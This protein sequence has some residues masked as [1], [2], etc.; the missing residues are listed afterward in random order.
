M[1]LRDYWPTAAP[2]TTK[3][4]TGRAA[5]AHAKA[6]ASLCDTLFKLVLMALAFAAAALLLR[7]TNAIALHIPHDPNEGWNAYLARAAMTGGPLYPQGLMVNNYP[8]LSFY[9]VAA[10][11]TITGDPIVAGRLL[12]LAAF[13]A[14]AISIIA[15]LREMGACVLGALFG[16]LFF[17]TGLLA[18]SGYVAMNDPQMLGHALQ[19]GALSLLLQKNRRET[20]PAALAMAAGLFI[21]HNLIALPLAAAMW[22]AWQ[23]RRAAVR[24][25][26]S[27]LVFCVAGLVLVRLLLDVNLFTALASPRLWAMKNFLAGSGQFLSWSGAGLVATALQVWRGRADAAVRLVA[28][29]SGFA[30]AIG[31]LF[32]FGDGVDANIFFDAAIALSLGAG[33]ALGNIPKRWASTLALF[34]ALPL[35]LYLEKNV[36]ASNFSFSDVFAREARLDIGFVRAHPGPA[37]CEDLTLCFWAGKEEPVDVFNLSEAIIRE[38]RG[39]GDLAHLL[40]TQYFGSIA[41][42]SLTP[43]ALGP[44]L[45][46]VLLAHY[47]TV[48]QD[49]NGV[50]MERR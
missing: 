5:D 24:F 36:T 47:R 1:S 42:S 16:A 21:K 50:F 32:A 18:A 44:H 45:N 3:F 17:A 4:F 41:L 7:D 25:S 29:Y 27:G 9:V 28:L 43:F 23:D 39:D 22:L 26:V 46:S 34:V 37:L 6:Q 33:L 13:I 38:K 48:R 31:G 49:D 19:L 8:P 30:L 14:A 10:L 2:L 12:S 40:E 20:I 35:G 15:I 11:S